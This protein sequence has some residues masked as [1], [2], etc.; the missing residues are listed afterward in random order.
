MYFVFLKQDVKLFYFL[1]YRMV[2]K[3]Y[4]VYF[5]NIEDY[6]LDLFM[7]RKGIDFEYFVQ[8]LW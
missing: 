7:C 5:M 3:K 4:Y 8:F 1:N 6:N 2:V